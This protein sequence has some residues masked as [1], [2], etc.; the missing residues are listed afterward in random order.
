MLVAWQYGIQ[1]NDKFKLIYEEYT[2]DGKFA[3]I[4]KVLGAYFKNYDNEYYYVITDSFPSLPRFFVGTPDESFKVEI[5]MRGGN[6]GFPRRNRG[7]R[8]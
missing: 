7:R 1:N 6:E 5:R 4:G 2:I 3:G 8:G